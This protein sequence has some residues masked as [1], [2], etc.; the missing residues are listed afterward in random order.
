M[1]WIFFSV[2]SQSEFCR[3]EGQNQDVSRAVLSLKFLVK[4]TSLLLSRL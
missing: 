3:L 4:D 1:V 2:L